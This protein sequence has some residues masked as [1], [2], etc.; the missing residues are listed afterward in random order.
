MGKGYQG[1]TRRVNQ[2]QGAKFFN[3]NGYPI[4][5]SRGETIQPLA[6][7]PRFRVFSPDGFGL[8]PHLLLDDPDALFELKGIVQMTGWRTEDCPPLSV[9][10]L[11]I[12]AIRP[13]SQT[14]SEPCRGPE[15]GVT[16][17]IDCGASIDLTASLC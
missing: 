2:K 5:T 15:H 11:R 7:L 16:E 14:P 4:A 8:S 6:A 12:A 3:T 1:S 13:C 10:D 17:I 9:F